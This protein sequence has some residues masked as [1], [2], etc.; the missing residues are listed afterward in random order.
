M[1]T[2]QQILEERNFIKAA[3]DRSLNHLPLN[4][5]VKMYDALSSMTHAEIAELSPEVIGGL[6]ASAKLVLSNYVVQKASGSN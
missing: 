3:N 4:T 5:L 2:V 6:V 1:Y